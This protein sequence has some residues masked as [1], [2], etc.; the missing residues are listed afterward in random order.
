MDYV[1][2]VLVSYRRHSSN[3]STEADL[4]TT[5]TKGNLRFMNRIFERGSLP[6]DLQN[7]RKK[8][9][10]NLYLDAAA[11]AYSAGMGKQGKRWLETALRYDEQL[12]S[13]EPPHWVTSLCGHALG[14]LVSDLREYLRIVSDNLPEREG[15]KKWN[16][17]RLAAHL[18][19]SMAFKRHQDGH[20]FRARIAAF[21]AC[22]ADLSLL[23]NRGLWAIGLKG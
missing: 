15:F 18:R 8:V 12:D 22:C 17:M 7:L 19:A 1:R 2:E 13:G 16:Q 23:R 4:V 11:R 5:F 3:A 6:P 20:R 9:I 14:T 10:G 21:Q